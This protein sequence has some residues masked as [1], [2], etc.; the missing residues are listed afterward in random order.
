MRDLAVKTIPVVVHNSRNHTTVTDTEQ[1][2]QR[3]VKR[4]GKIL[5]ESIRTEQHEEYESN[6]SQTSDDEADFE[7]IEYEELYQEEP[8]E[9]KTR[10]EESFIEYFQNGQNQ[11]NKVIN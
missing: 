2:K 9:Y 4:G 1:V 7:K 3:N 10:T 8:K 5:T 6:D 11:D